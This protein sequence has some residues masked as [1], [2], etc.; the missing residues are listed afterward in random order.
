MPALCPELVQLP[1]LPSSHQASHCR[2]LHEPIDRIDLG[3]HFDGDVQVLDVCA[4]HSLK[5]ITILIPILPFG[6]GPVSRPF[7][8]PLLGLQ[9]ALKQSLARRCPGHLGHLGVSQKNPLATHERLDL[10]HGI[11]CSA[12]GHLHVIHDLSHTEGLGAH[13]VPTVPCRQAR[14]QILRLRCGPLLDNSSLAV[15]LY[16]SDHGE[17]AGADPQHIL[18]RLPLSDDREFPDVGKLLHLDGEILEVVEGERPGAEALGDDGALAEEF[19]TL[20]DV[21]QVCLSDELVVHV[22][23]QDKAVQVLRGENRGGARDVLG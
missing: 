16:T 1:A 5:I 7:L 2:H 9:L 14:H 15:K 21:H 11:F 12:L 20:V 18:H 10:A 8:G 4:Q 19:D 13:S 23:I 22:T 3:P 6:L 17:A